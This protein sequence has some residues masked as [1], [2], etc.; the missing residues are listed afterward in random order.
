[1][2]NNKVLLL[3]KYGLE[4]KIYN[5]GNEFCS[6]ETCTL[7]AWLN[8]TFLNEAFD[9]MEKFSILPTTV[10]NRVCQVYNGRIID[11]NENTQ[12]KIFLLSCA[13]AKKYLCVDR[14]FR[15]IVSRTAPTEY[16]IKTG[17]R[18]DSQYKT[19]DGEA[20]VR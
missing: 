6:W 15:N 11:R 2:P 10:D 1:M 16:A 9:T 4:T 8:S 19:V 17:V 20:P 3:S 5:K 14:R 18:P 7:H 13:E 12:D